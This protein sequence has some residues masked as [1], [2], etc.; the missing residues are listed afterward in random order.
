MRP[1]WIL[2]L[3]ASGCR[4]ILGIEQ[5][6]DVVD[7]AIDVVPACAMWRPHGFDPCALGVALPALH[8]G[9]GQ[10]VYDTTLDGGKLTDGAGQLVAQSRV[11][12]MQP[13][14]STAAVLSL[15]ALGLDAGATL[16]VIGPR[17]LL[18]AAWS[19]AV[20][21][22]AIDAGSHTGVPAL[23]A[24]ANVVCSA[25]TAGLD[26][27]NATMNGGSG[28]GGGAGGQGHGGHGGLGGASPQVAGGAG[29]VAGPIVAGAAIHGGCPGGA[30]GAA[31]GVAVLPAT[32]A[33]QSR[34]G[35]GGG[36]IWLAA[37]DSLAIAGSITAN[38][39]GG[40]GAQLGSVC[41]GGGGGAGGAV[42]LDAPSVTISGAV[43]ANGGGGGG[44]GAATDAGNDGADGKADL[45]AAPGGALAAKGCGR[46]G[47]AGSAQLALAGSDAAGSDVCG[48]GGGGGAAGFVTVAST[49]Y[50]ATGTAKISPPAISP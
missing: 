7:A 5:P 16:R 33:T 41:G 6:L 17:P 42:A 11:T 14:G 19:T 4:G 27:A 24:D 31:G 36:A 30:S 12:V 18:I 29:G 45:Q 50:T 48:G 35:A 43:T 46:P 47:G 8:L 28:G 21:D 22:G 26:G 15:D 13:D 3:A 49:S 25:G 32:P 40:A 20:I 44:G 34:G 9:P 2:V 37:R 38:G 23:G 1:A 10:Y 39:A